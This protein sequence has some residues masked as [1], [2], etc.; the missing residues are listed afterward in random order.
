MGM[1]DNTPSRYGGQCI[2]QKVVCISKCTNLGVTLNHIYHAIKKSYKFGSRYL[3][4]SD[5]D[6][7]QF[8]YK[9]KHFKI[10]EGK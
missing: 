7:F 9:T 3:I 1:F 8:W 4:E 6:G 2:N 5:D 10:E